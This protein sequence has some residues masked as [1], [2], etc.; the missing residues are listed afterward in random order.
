MTYKIK[1]AKAKTDLTVDFNA[2][3]EI[4]QRYIIEY[5][6]GQK[7]ND[8]GAHATVKELGEEEA[9]AQALSSAESVLTALMAGNITQRVSAARATPLDKIKLKIAKAIF[10]K[11]FGDKPEKGTG[12]D[13]LISAIAEKTEK[14]S[15]ALEG[16]ITEKATAQMEIE[17]QQADLINSIDI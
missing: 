1:L 6:L 9:A 7:L 10:G 16:I 3:P 2:M 4:A 5:G 12:F 15:E 11:V 13:D 8:S 14:D 17:K